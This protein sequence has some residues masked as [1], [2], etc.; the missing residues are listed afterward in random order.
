[1]L[2]FQP[3]K[4]QNCFE[5]SNSLFFDYDWLFSAANIQPH[6]ISAVCFRRREERTRICE[7]GVPTAWASSPSEPDSE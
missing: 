2:D 3:K 4:K 7:K 1:M 6:C 5:L